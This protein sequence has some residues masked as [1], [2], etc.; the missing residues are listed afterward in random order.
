M[1]KEVSQWRTKPSRMD[2][3]QKCDICRRPM[4]GVV[5]GSMPPARRVCDQ[6]CQDDKGA[7]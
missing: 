2:L 6:C 7:A 4:E 3:Y 1:T 5:R